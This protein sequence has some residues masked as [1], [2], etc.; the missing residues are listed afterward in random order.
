M[1]ILKQLLF[2]KYGG[3][4]DKRIKHLE[5]GSKFIVDDRSGKDVG[6]DRRLYSNFCMIFADVMSADEVRVS[7]SGNVPTSQAVRD[8]AS[9]HNAVQAGNTL[10]IQISKGQQSALRSLAKAIRAITA[11][12][13]KYDVKSYKYVCPRTADSLEKL[14]GVLDSAWKE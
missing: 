1:K 5:S 2:E 11:R 7:L 12:G 4:A 8:W 13:A 3:F 6:A 9:S 14:A 10:D